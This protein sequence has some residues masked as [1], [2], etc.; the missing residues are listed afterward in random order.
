M[1]YQYARSEIEAVRMLSH[2]EKRGQR[3]YIVQ[4]RPDCFEIRTWR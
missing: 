4:L 2:A 1:T 3:G